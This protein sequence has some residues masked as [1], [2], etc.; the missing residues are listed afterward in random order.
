[1][2]NTVNE[3]EMIKIGQIW[4]LNKKT[5]IDK[6]DY[7]SYM[8]VLS[9]DREFWRLAIFHGYYEGWGGAGIIDLVED[10]I[11]RNAEVVNKLE[12]IVEP[13]DSDSTARTFEEVVSA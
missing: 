13:K 7:G 12:D 4:E 9:K 2:P 5:D 11:T 1:M 3:K 8:I 10:E 6:M